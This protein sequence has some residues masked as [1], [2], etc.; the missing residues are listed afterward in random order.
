[1]ANLKRSLGTTLALAPVPAALISCCTP[2]GKPNL[3]TLAWVGVVCSEPPMVA[4]AIR[5]SRYSYGLVKA[6]GEF[7]VNVPSADQVK[8]VDLCGVKSGR[9][10]DKFALA[11]FTPGLATRVK[12]PIVAE[13]P[14]NLEC[15]VRQTLVLG[16]H[17]LFIGEVVAVQASEEVFD[18][19]GKLD[20]GK[21]N[22]LGFLSGEYWSSGEQVGDYGFSVRK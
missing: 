4:I 12:P 6:T 9:D 15:V 8:A 21:V 18:E 13:C 5:P 3:I 2:E 19:A 17:E 7:V 20:W 16:T 1:M 10:Q 14:I 11:G 22:P